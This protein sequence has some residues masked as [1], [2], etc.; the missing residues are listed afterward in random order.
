MTEKYFKVVF[1]LLFFFLIF[2]HAKHR[3]VL[4]PRPG[5]EPMPLAV[6]VQSL[7]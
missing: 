1:S 5:I 7:S 6:K 2:G 4:V 3:G